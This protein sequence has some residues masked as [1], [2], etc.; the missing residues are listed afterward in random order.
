MLSSIRKH[1]RSWVVKALFAL[2]IAAFA[3]WGI[4]ADM[5][6][7]ARTTQPILKIGKNFEY[8]AVDFDREMKLSL[9]RLSQ[10]QGVQVTAAMFAAFGGAQRLVDQAES[11]GLLQAYG[12]ELGIDVPQQAAVQMI[13]SDPDFANQAGQFDRS[14]F[15]YVLRQLGQSEAQ[16]VETIRGQLRA[17]QILVAMMGGIQAPEP[18]V[19]AVYLYTQEQRSAELVVVPTASIT[20]AGTPDDAAIKKWH[21]DHAEN[22]KAPEYRA[23]QL[24]Q[25]TPADFVQDVSVSDEEIQQEYD[26]R[27][28][29]FSTPEIRDVEQ[30]VVQDK[31]VADAIL[32]ATKGGKIFAEAVKEA[33]QGDPVALGQVTKDKLPADIAEQVFALPADGVSG[34]LKS[35]FG[36]H[37]VH[38]QSVIPGSTRTLEEVKGE[39]RNALALGR[40]ADTMESVRE[41]LQDE[42]AGGATLADAATKLQLRLQM[43]DAVD[44]TGKDLT[45]T[46]LGIAADAVALIFSTEPGEPG[47]ITALNDGSYAIVQ[48]TSVTPP[49]VKPLDQVKDQIIQ[50]WIAAKQA[51]LAQ[52]KAQAL[53][54]KLKPGGDLA[55]EATALGLTLGV[56]KPFFRGEGDAENGV[57]PALAQALF[58]L[59]VG[60]LTIGDGPDGPIVARLT[61]ITPASPETHADDVKQLSERVAQSLAGDVQQQFFDALKTEIPV[62][63]DDEQWRKLIEQPDQ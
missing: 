9:Q 56:S 3:G 33:T 5:F 34:A 31:A 53:V 28:A 14:R 20:D 24:L 63:R 41:Q 6:S 23:A 45:G 50:D 13:E 32:A 8:T 25:M 37:V 11:K 60:E 15:E 42:L 35:P 38:V 55:A 10:I 52:A 4:G 46:D 61:G 58:K 16:Y 49:A 18:L 43:V 30:V 51:E 19:R 17:N 29:E 40:A 47:D 22:Y 39:L 62:E 36:L 2:L 44:A 21:E 26:S 27:K 57:N 7:G 1:S 48:V 12:E 59:K 54:E